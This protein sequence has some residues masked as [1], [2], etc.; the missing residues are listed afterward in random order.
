MPA[1]G[2][3]EKDAAGEPTGVLRRAAVSLVSPK[4]PPPSFD[5][6]VEGLKLVMRDFHAA[7]PP[8][9]SR[10]RPHPPISSL[11]RGLTTLAPPSLSV[12]F[13]QQS[14]KCTSVHKDRRAWKIS[15]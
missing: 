5:E 8:R 7:A 13:R 3:I 10:P 1:G 9:P 2:V 6:K 15:G 14:R 4:L 12:A 11:P